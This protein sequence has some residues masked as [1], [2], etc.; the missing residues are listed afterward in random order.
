MTMEDYQLAKGVVR[1]TV[2]MMMTSADLISED[3]PEFCTRGL[4]FRTRAGSQIRSRNKMRCKV[5]VLN[6]QDIQD[7]EGIHDQ[8]LLSFASMSESR[9]VREEALQRG[10]DDERC[11]QEYCWDV[12]QISWGSSPSK[13]N[14]SSRP[15]QLPQRPRSCG[16]AEQQEDVGAEQPTSSPSARKQT[17]SILT[18]KRCMYYM[19]QQKQH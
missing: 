8:E 12:R 7:E 16:C 3:D 19:Q 11:I 1:T 6:E 5:A 2:R 10:L 14:T 15:V 18:H 13:T 17:K 4:E 9:T